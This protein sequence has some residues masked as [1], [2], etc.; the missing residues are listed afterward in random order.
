MMVMMM[1]TGTRRLLSAVNS[2]VM[3]LMITSRSIS[4]D[5]ATVY[6]LVFIEILNSSLCL[7][8]ID[9]VIWVLYSPAMLVTLVML[10][11]LT[12]LILIIVLFGNNVRG[13]S[14]VCR[15]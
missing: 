7:I 14:K 5:D 4:T 1:I 6:K 3:T 2:L 11:T 8:D 10:V 9:M 12:L 13:V 15:D